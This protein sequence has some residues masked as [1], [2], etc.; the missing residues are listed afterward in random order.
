MSWIN[1]EIWTV[2]A[3]KVKKYQWGSEYWHSQVYYLPFEHFFY[4]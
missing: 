4:V 3:K 1:D 2:Y